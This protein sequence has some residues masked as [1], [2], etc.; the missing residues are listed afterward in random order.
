MHACIPEWQHPG[1]SCTHTPELCF[2]RQQQP[3][4]V[5]AHL[6]QTPAAHLQRQHTSTSLTIPA[7]RSSRRAV[8][9][10]QGHGPLATARLHSTSLQLS[11]TDQYAANSMA[12]GVS[13]LNCHSNCNVYTG[14]CV[15]NALHVY[16]VQTQYQQTA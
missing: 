11:V 10:A 8:L 9:A 12:Q 7:N 16:R 2:A 4:T 3:E 13:A 1:C 15:T 5:L 6:P 14:R